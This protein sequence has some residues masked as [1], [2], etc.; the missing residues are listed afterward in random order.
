MVK[1]TVIFVYNPHRRK[2]VK[3]YRFGIELPSTFTTS[4]CE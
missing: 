4:P 3:N 1:L 2:A